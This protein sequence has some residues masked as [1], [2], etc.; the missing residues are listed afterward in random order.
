VLPFSECRGQT[1]EIRYG[2]MPSGS[3]QYSETT[4]QTS[5]DFDLKYPGSTMTIQ[6]LSGMGNDATTSTGFYNRKWF[7]PSLS[8]EYIKDT[9][10]GGVNP[11]QEFRYAEILLN[12]AEAVME[13]K[14][15][16]HVSDEM[17]TKAAQ[18]IRDI[19]ERAGAK[20]DKYDKNTLTI[21]AVR[22]ERRK[23]FYLENKIFWDLKRWRVF[24][25]EVN[26]KRWN[27]LKPVY[28]WD[29][30][31]YYLKRDSTEGDA[32]TWTFVINN[33]YS[34]IPNRDKNELMIGN[35]TENF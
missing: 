13:L 18:Y 2:I 24:H 16:D 30:Q 21:D 31:K 23:E 33:Y 26:S 34:D 19:R 1:I 17:L 4:V 15:L 14:S 6:G 5:A 11:W 25:E 9:S 8:D 3:S 7:D 35:P 27:L 22:M 10:H 29:K 28:F 12:I 20:V 32:A